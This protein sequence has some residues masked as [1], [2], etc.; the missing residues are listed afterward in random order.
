[1]TLESSEVENNG[2]LRS[3][4]ARDS[5]FPI[6]KSVIQRYFRKSFYMSRIII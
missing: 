2:L 1:M 4:S 5:V 6:I 3:A